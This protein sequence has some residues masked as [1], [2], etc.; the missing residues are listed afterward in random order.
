MAEPGRKRAGR[1]SA[2]WVEV[3]LDVIDD[4]DGSTRISARQASE[5]AHLHE[6][7]KRTKRVDDLLDEARVNFVAVALLLDEGEDGACQLAVLLL[8]L[9][10]EAV[11]PLDEAEL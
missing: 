4:D 9:E 8:D 7:S 6:K 1:V 2:F 10:E 11:A 5:R 3:C